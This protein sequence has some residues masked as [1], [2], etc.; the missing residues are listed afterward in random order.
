VGVG[1]SD[2]L[3]FYTS[4]DR[5]RTWRITTTLHQAG[6]GDGF[7]D[8]VAPGLWWVITEDASTV[9]VTSDAGRNWQRRSTGGLSGVLQ[10]IE[11]EAD[12]RAW[13]QII[14]GTRPTIEATTD[15]GATWSPVFGP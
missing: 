5:G 12:H 3:G 15:G 10:K 4:A 11:A 14:E 6:A 8:I 9:L 13:V 2:R 1:E 7:V